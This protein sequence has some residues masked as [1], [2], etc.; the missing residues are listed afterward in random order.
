MRSWLRG[1]HSKLPLE[2]K[3]ISINHCGFSPSG[4]FSWP[5]EALAICSHHL[6][7]NIRNQQNKHC[8]YG[9]FFFF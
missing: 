5:R 3:L 1:L 4:V 2:L 9:Y 8:T 7:K 6:V